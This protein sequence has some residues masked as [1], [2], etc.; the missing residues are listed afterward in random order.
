MGEEGYVDPEVKASA[1]AIPD[2]FCVKCK[3]DDRKR[4]NECTCPKCRVKR[5]GRELAE[6]I[7]CEECQEGYHFDCVGYES[8]EE[9]P[10]EF[11]CPDC[12]NENNINHRDG[13]KIQLKTRRFGQKSTEK[14]GN[15]KLYAS[16]PEHLKKHVG[17]VPGEEVG[18][19]YYDRAIAMI[20]GVHTLLQHGIVADASRVY[21]ICSSG[22]YAN[23]ADRGDEL[24]FTGSGGNDLSGNKR[25]AP[26]T[27]N[28]TME[29]RRGQGNKWLAQCCKCQFTEEGG[30]SG[31]RWRDGKPIRVMRGFAKTK[32]KESNPF[33]PPE[34]YRY[35]G[36][37]KVVRY[38][39]DF[40]TNGIFVYKY[41]LRRDDPIPAP[42]TE[43]GRERIEELGIS[44]KMYPMGEYV[45]KM[46]E[47]GLLDRNGIRTDRP[48][49][50]DFF[51]QTLQKKK[52]KAYTPPEKLLETIGADVTFK[53]AWDDCLEKCAE[54]K[55]AF[56]TEVKV[57]F[58]CVIQ[59][60]P[61]SV[62]WSEM[63]GVSH[64]LED[65]TVCRY[66]YC[67]SCARNTFKN[68]HVCPFCRKDLG[69]GFS[70]QELMKGEENSRLQNALREFKTGVA[71]TV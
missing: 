17:P 32:K 44:M 63:V 7:V 35:D 41:L 55:V 60:C 34:G 3:D 9:A 66:F 59:A 52:A 57:K 8:L 67:P 28:Q 11:Y 61:Q 48:I 68:N 33:D 2:Y 27:M 54:G 69:E 19:V 64:T 39:K 47:A 5:P 26:Q 22:G 53:K 46:N 15:G 43:E 25:N 40:R 10:D 23:D 6:C 49:P 30:D 70:I 37:Y 42:W 65:G 45:F 16:C 18:Q 4:C 13:N 20:H 71:N 29:G 36:I 56:E 51:G 14:A 12:K 24:E 31:D 1:D 38:W 50:E 62:D 58:E 21:S